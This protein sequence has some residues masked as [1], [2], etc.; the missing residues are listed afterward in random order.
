VHLS[1]NTLPPLKSRQPQKI[2]LSSH[3]T[4]AE[5]GKFLHP[6]EKASLSRDIDAMLDRARA[7]RDS[8]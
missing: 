7:V 2:I 8:N 3:G 5:I 1:P 4:H 6:A